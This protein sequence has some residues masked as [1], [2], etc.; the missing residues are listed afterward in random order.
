MELYVLS[1]YVRLGIVKF[2]FPSNFATETF[3]AFLSPHAFYLPCPSLSPSSFSS[4]RDTGNEAYTTSYA[5]RFCSVIFPGAC[6]LLVCTA[7]VFL[8]S[9]G[10]NGLARFISFRLFCFVLIVFLFLS[11]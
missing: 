5:H 11:N 6:V 2:S 9:F 1:F 4:F 7:E 3:W 8:H 10:P